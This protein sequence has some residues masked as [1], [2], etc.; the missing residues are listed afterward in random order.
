MRLVVAL[1]FLA[2]WIAG[3]SAHDLRPGYLAITEKGPSSYEVEWKVPALGD[4]RLALYPRFPEG[5]VETE[6]VGALLSDSYF[7]RW[8]V[9]APG[10]LTGQT[11]AVDGLTSIRTDVLVRLE[12]VDGSAQTMR[13][14]SAAPS[15]VVEASQG[16]LEVA[17]SYFGLGVEHI[18]LG[19]DHLLFVLALVLLIGGWKRLAAAITAFTVA[20]SITLAAATLGVVSVPTRLVETLIALSI[21][22]LAVEVAR[23]WKGERGLTG[24]YPWLVAFAFGLLHGLGFA[25]GLAELGLPATDIPLALL[26]FNLGVEAGQIAFVGVI[27]LFRSAAGALPFL[28]N[29]AVAMAPCYVVGVAGAYWSIERLVPLLRDTL[30]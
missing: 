1:G 30:A 24:Q 10:G 14:T 25:N 7:E 27:F 15:F 29:P 8:R 4:L 20:H 11:I 26:S 28:R 5:T 21:L 6:R 23:A 9:D 2:A 12:R 17:R 22:F 18:L 16:N 13:L 3:A 19:V